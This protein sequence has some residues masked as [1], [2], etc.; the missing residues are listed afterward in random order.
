MILRSGHYEIIYPANDN[1][2]HIYQLDE[3]INV[4]EKLLQK[5]SSSKL[6]ESP[7]R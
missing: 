3:P 6:I 2:S 4:K 7:S 5:K 1:Y